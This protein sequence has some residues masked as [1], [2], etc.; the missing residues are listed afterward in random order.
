R[1]DANLA[2]VRRELSLPDL[3]SLTADADVL[4]VLKAI[5]ST[6][7]RRVRAWGGDLYFVM[8]PNQDDY[9]GKIPPHR[10]A[11]L[12]VV[13]Q[14]G[15]PVIDLDRPLRASGDPLQFY[16]LRTGWGHFN[17]EGYRLFAYSL[18]DAMVERRQL[19]ADPIAL[20][21]LDPGNR[22]LARVNALVAALRRLNPGLSSNA[23]L[24]L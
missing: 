4:R 24:P 12:D 11:V 20:E 14:I 6:A 16:P 18:I 9:R 10:R 8:I 22:R 21:E 15:L 7:E 13:Q 2:T 5:L 19:S 23:L 17:P 1:G 3:G